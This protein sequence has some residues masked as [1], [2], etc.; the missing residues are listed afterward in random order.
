MDSRRRLG[1]SG[2]QTS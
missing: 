1:K 2:K